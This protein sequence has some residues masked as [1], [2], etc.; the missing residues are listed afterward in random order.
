[1]RRGIATFGFLA[2]LAPAALGVPL[3]LAF[4]LLRSTTPAC[5]W[6]PLP[7]P[8]DLR[9]GVEVVAVDGCLEARPLPVPRFNIGL[10]NGKPGDLADLKPGAV[11]S[12][13]DLRGA[14]WDGVELTAVTLRHVDLGE[15]DLTTAHLA[16]ARFDRCNL[17]G[18]HL[19]GAD[20]TGAVLNQ[21]D[22]RGVCSPGVSFRIAAFRGCDLRRTGLDTA[23][24][25]G[26][27]YDR[28]TR[29]PAGFDPRAAGAR[30][31]E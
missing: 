30:L 3:L 7:A 29:W 20:L 19:D 5:T 24:L 26:A 13:T 25:K 14:R 23:N 1:M 27:T 21:C 18:A 4:T 12:D 9:S 2:R 28:H 10:V 6:D 8:L 16:M 22:L 31:E 11:L 15:A 17:N